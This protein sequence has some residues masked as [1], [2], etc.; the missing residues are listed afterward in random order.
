M[1]VPLADIVR[2]LDQ[3]RDTR[4]SVTLA[5]L[6]V[7]RFRRRE[8]RTLLAVA[9]FAGVNVT[10]HEERGLIESVFLIRMEGR[11]SLLRRHLNRLVVLGGSE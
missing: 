3:R 4:V 1:N 5:P 6:E 11:A 10:C 9:R 2:E 7:G 8:V